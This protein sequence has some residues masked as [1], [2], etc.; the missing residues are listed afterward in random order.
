MLGVDVAVDGAHLAA[1]HALQRDRVR[2]DDGDVKAALPR[3]GGELGA[4]PAGADDDDRAAALEP[5]AQCVGVADAAQVVHAIQRRRPARETARLG[6]GGE[7]Q[8]VVV[9]A[10]RHRRALSSRN[11]VFRSTAVRPRRSSMCVSA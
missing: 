7:Q 3:R 11:C 4:D 2:V 6:P 9:Q 5:F 8:P 1:E 10:T